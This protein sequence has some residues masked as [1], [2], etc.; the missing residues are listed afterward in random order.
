[1][2]ALE[3]TTKQ[4]KGF[5]AFCRRIYTTLGFQ[6]GYNFVLWFTLAGALFGFSI[7]RLAYLNFNQNLCPATSAPGN[8]AAPGECYYYKTFTQYKVG[9][10]LH[11][12][13]VL[14]AGIIAFFQFIP[15]IRHKAILVHRIMGYIAL[16]LFVAGTIGAFMIARHSFGG[17]LDTQAFIGV[18]AIATL[19]SFAMA[20]IN[21]K[22]LQIEQHRAWMLRGWVYAG[23]IITSRIIMIITA[24][25][26]SSTHAYHAVWPCAK[27]A[28]TLPASTALLT[29]YPACASYLDGSNPNQVAIVAADMTAGSPVTAGAALNIGFGMALWVAGAIHAVGVEIY[30]HLT[31]KESQRLRQVSYQRQ[32]EAGMRKPGSAGLTADRVGDAPPFVPE[33]EDGDKLTKD[34]SKMIMLLFG[35]IG[36][37]FDGYA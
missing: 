32:L 26:I 17:G 29:A 16:L 13:G 24:S 14:P 22:R 20:I 6:K 8:S 34:V 28:H 35:I 11:L 37:W 31:P 30:L 33:V 36:S 18:V 23:G 19:G 15:I 21:I 12:A 3:P 25:I 27:I 9:I 4:P 7:A 1:M 2:G 5:K 10:M